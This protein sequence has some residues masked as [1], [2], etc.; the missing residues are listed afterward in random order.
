MPYTFIYIVVFCVFI[1][2]YV[3]GNDM[4]INRTLFFIIVNVFVH[5]FLQQSTD[6]KFTTLIVVPRYKSGVSQKISVANWPSLFNELVNICHDKINLNEICFERGTAID[7]F[8]CNF[9]WNIIPLA[10]ACVHP[11][12]DTNQW[13][14]AL[15][16]IYIHW[17]FPL[18]I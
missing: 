15:R 6:E 13:F 10:S 8:R 16:H 18:T 7:G 1:S 11:K 4:G 5:T 2:C 12:L 3:D 17:P 9:Q 14:P